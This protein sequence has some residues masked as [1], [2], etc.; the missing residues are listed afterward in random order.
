ME[1]Y[2]FKKGDKV[3]LPFKEKGKVVDF[4][5]MMWFTR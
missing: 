1:N 5:E 4:Q 3:L 2:K